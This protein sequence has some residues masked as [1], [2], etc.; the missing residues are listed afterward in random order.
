MRA[1]LISTGTELLRGKVNQD[2]SLVCRALIARGIEPIR[3]VT[4]PDDVEALK[5]ELDRGFQMADLVFTFGGLGPTHDDQTKRALAE[6]FGGQIRF[7][8]PY[9]NS[10]LP[11]LKK[12]G[13]THLESYRAFAEL[14]EG[15]EILSN[16]RGLAPALIRKTDVGKFLIALPGPPQE[17]LAIL[18]GPLTPYLEQWGTD[19]H[20][21]VALH[22]FGLTEPELMA[23]LE[24]TIGSDALSDLSIIPDV[25]GI[26]LYVPI[27]PEERIQKIR[28]ML[29]PHLYGEGPETLEYV[30]GRLLRT[31]NWTV[32]T[33]ESLTGG[34]VGHLITQVHGSSDYYQGGMV[35]YSDFAKRQQLGV[36]HQDLLRYGAVSE[37]VAAQMADGVRQKFGT[38]VGLSTTGIAGPTGG[39]PLKPVGLVY[40]GLS[41]Q[42][43]TRVFRRVFSG[44]REDIK[45]HAAYTLLDLLR[46]ALLGVL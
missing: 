22:L 37:P 13:R 33:A 40:L 39:T 2:P 23:M 28:T 1:Y 36:R 9:F 30:I 29:G 38:D 44:S 35:T 19:K 43:K 8:A 26:H 14:P 46:R 31:R 7:H 4:L 16:P 34:L 20:R 6:Y 41:I 18:H 45:F 17:V 10:L 3:E 15:F 11:R 32:A 24:D 27:E 12:T 25:D 5:V 42:G 21:T